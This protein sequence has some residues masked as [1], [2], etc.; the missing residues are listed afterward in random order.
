MSAR[1][2]GLRARP[3]VR[4][5]V[6]VSALSA[7]AL[8]GCSANSGDAQEGDAAASD[9]DKVTVVT[10]TNVYSDLVE[11]VAGDHVDVTPIID[12]AAQD[13]HSYEA[14]P[15][16]RLTI[17]K[18]DVVILNGGGYD[19]FME[20]MTTDSQKVINAVDVSELEGKEEAAEAHD[21]EGHEGHHHEPGGFNEHV[22]Y[23]L[24][25]MQTLT[26]RIA[27]QLGEIDQ[28]RSKEFTDNATAL[29]DRL[30]GMKTELESLKA[31][32]GYVATE[33]MPGYLLQ[34]AGLHDDTPAE[35]MTAIDSE[36]D[37]APAVMKETT[38][39]VTSGH[40]DLLAFNQQT[41]TGQT[42]KL[43][44]DAEKSGVSVVEFSET[45][46]DGKNYQEWMQDNIDRVSQAVK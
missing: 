7:L 8:T 44:E 20:D 31:S 9:G 21:E 16:D 29:N 43:R 27:E 45:L 24:D 46:P 39:L 32:G 5:A 19:A 14:S 2:Q 12:S 28:D 30:S 25:T 4:S 36:S 22:W 1:V 11:Q 23:D 41:S 26:E 6:A 3:F 38:D 18:A 42:E 17:E 40:I 15:Q 33:P 10:S 35:F 13:P 37:V 34:D